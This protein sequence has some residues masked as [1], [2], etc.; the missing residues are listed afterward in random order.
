MAPLKTIERFFCI[1][2]SPAGLCISF[3]TGSWGKLGLK[4][5]QELGQRIK[6]ITG[7]KQS[8]SYLFQ[9]IGMAVQRG[10]AASV[11]GTIPNNRKL[12]ELFQL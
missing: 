6:D 8:A 9:R 12:E 3:L 10:N 5:I 7:E 1:S 4:F 11:L 2:S